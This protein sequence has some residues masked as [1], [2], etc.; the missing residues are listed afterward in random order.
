M[1]PI[2]DLAPATV[3]R[4]NG[5]LDDGRG[6]HEPRR[7]QPGHPGLTLR[8]VLLIIRRSWVI[9]LVT[10]LVALG[11]G[12]G[13]TVITP[14]SYEAQAAVLV[15]PAVST[16]AGSMAQA[17]SFVANQVATYA[18]LAET[19]A[20][21]DPAI[22]SA[23]VHV[24]SS[25][26]ASNVSSELVPETSIIKLTVDVQSAREAAQLA[27]AI[28]GTLIA[29]IEEQ[30]PPGGAVRVT[31]SVVESPQAPTVPASP[32]LSYNLLVAGAIGLLVAFLTI[33]FRQALAVGTRERP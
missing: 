7:Y 14:K 20:V 12:W 11:A 22:K 13:I 28:A 29:Q 21:L 24:A 18:A 31:G 25:Q 17:A 5:A 27:N 33:V 8:D 6:L 15:A 3:S 2:G 26:L 10:V 16:D 4:E 32:K 30:T 1:T 23:G 19:P 9:L